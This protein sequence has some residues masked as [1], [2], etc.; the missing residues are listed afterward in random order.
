MTITHPD[1]MAKVQEWEHDGIM[2]PRGLAQC[3]PYVYGMEGVSAYER[4][5]HAKMVDMV[6]DGWLEPFPVGGINMSGLNSIERKG[7]CAKIRAVIDKELE[8]LLCLSGI[9]ARYCRDLAETESA[10]TIE[11]KHKMLTPGLRES[12][13]KKYQ[14]AVK[15]VDEV[16]DDLNRGRFK[17]QRSYGYV[18]DVI[19][20]LVCSP[21]QR[22]ICTLTAISRVYGVSVDRVCRDAQRVKKVL[23]R[24]E[25][26]AF[27]RLTPL[28]R[29]SDLIG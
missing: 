13:A 12:Y 2:F 14:G 21:R 27:N 5:V 24:I 26:D 23:H 25:Q 15:L 28:F 7:E 10:K 6:N 16:H 20:H 4:S 8:G 22:D 17:A 3:M 9:H 29:A 11:E 18:G 1:Q 19:W